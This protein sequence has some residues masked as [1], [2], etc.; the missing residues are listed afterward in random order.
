M[1]RVYLLDQKRREYLGT[2]P[3][4]LLD[5]VAAEFP[6]RWSR[7]LSAPLLLLLPLLLA[8]SLSTAAA[9]T[10]RVLRLDGLAEFTADIACASPQLLRE[11][12]V[13]A[14]A[15]C[16]RGLETFDVRMAQST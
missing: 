7:L 10:P 9:S 1:I 12:Y 11:S 2:E 6:R 16:C 8:E 4:L 14:G 15:L 5:A 3:L 13:A